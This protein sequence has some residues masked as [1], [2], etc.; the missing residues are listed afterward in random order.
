MIENYFAP[1]GTKI[2]LDN[3]HKSITVDLY[4]EEGLDMLSNLWTKVGAEHKMM[5][6]PTWL[7]RPIIQYPSDVIAIQE[8][9]WNTKPDVI[10][11]TGIAHG[12]SA[13]MSASILNLTGK[14]RVIAVDIDIR[15]HNKK[16]IEEHP[17]GKNIEM[18]ESSSI[19]LE[20]FNQI[21]SKIS[22]NDKVLVILDSNHSK[23]HVLE[24]L[25][26]YSQ[27]VTPGSYIVAHDGAQAWV[28]EIPRGKKEWKDDHPIAA[29]QSFLH[30]N[31]NFE[32]D[33]F[34]TRHKI[35][36]SPYGYLK[37]VK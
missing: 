13:I 28:A 15:E 2:T 30:E 23:D 36:C 21:K 25:R 26:L 14:G 10:I 20:T 9:I 34:Y 24:E 18:I 22:K 29:I 19:D 1:I 7:G 5:Y 4:A 33:D 35:T 16:A 31:D 11:E 32:V 27:L 12:G 6:K 37:K 17:F 8:L 3:G